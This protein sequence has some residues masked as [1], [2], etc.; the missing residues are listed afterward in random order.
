[1]K[2]ALLVCGA[3]VIALAAQEASAALVE[4]FDGYA[5]QAAFQSVWKPYSA[6]G[7]SMLLSAAGHS[8]KQR[9]ASGSSKHALIRRFPNGATLLAEMPV[10]LR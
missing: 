1:M 4:N 5:S 8:G 3:V 9:Y 7:S 2:K 10:A 6:D